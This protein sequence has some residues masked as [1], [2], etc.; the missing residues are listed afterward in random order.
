MWRLYIN[1][2]GVRICIKETET[3]EGIVAWLKANAICEGN[4]YYLG[5]DELTCYYEN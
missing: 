2:D 4:E 5:R 3:V 1:R